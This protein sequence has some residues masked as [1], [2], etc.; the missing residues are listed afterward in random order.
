M[1]TIIKEERD[2]DTLEQ[3][4]LVLARQ[5][6]TSTEQSP[7]I[8]TLQATVGNA[9]SAVDLGRGTHTESSSPF[10]VQST[11]GNAAAIG[12]AA[13]RKD[14]SAGIPSALEQIAFS[15]PSEPLAPDLREETEARVGADLGDLRIHRDEGA[16]RAAQTVEAT[17]FT[18]GK[19]IAFSRNAFQPETEA[20]KRLITHEAVHTIQQR[21]ATGVVHGTSDPHD[22]S[23]R[24]A[25]AIAS[26][27]TRV[28]RESAVGIIQRV[29]APPGSATY[30]R[31]KIAISDVSDFFAEKVRTTW[32]FPK[33]VVNVS[34]SEPS[35]AHIVWELYDSFDQMAQGFSTTTGSPRALNAP[36]DIDLNNFIQ[37]VVQGRYTLRC[38][39]LNASHKGVVY[40]DRSFFIWTTLPGSM[41]DLTTL[42]VVKAAPS[43]HS[44]GEVGSAYARAMML[45]HQAS[46]A[47][48][49][50]GT[51]QGNQCSTPAPQGVTQ[52]DCTTYVL[53]ILK[54]AFD[55][56]G[57]GADWTKVM[58]AARK[59]SG[60]ALKG[61]EVLKA[62]ETDAGWKGVFWSPDPRNPADTLP[63][64]ST[65]YKKVGESGQ[66]YGIAVDKAKSIVEYRR[67]SATKEET[68]TNLDK[69]KKVPLGVIAAKGGRH[70]T[71][72]LNGQVYEVHWDKSANDPNVIEATPLE[73]WA[74]NSGVIVMPADDFTKAFP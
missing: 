71:L 43:I 49:G 1:S 60:T 57:K 72:I 36:F 62:L 26:G 10:S 20:G 37:P 54:Q 17:A 67:T 58:A 39:G 61:T 22:R 68:W 40:A 13:G 70:M 11:Y 64:H 5:A 31:S 14:T 12:I 69:L 2:R 29:P 52:Q 55:A 66:Y 32:L 8:N 21:G 18:L 46:L 15:G 38:T 56:K 9:A 65:A 23:E 47:S 34:V 51:V 7:E 42:N 63:E 6:T 44:L 4:P 3:A 45:E 16:D 25:D 35:V 33:N 50:Q 59:A 24:E 48:G 53:L 74:W 30:D 28:P 41:H 73:K 19:N 27:S